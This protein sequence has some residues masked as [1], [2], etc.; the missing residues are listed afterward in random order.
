[1]KNRAELKKPYAEIDGEY[2][3]KDVW[4]NALLSVYGIDPERVE[5]IDG[6][7]YLIYKPTKELKDV[8]TV[9]SLGSATVKLAAYMQAYKSTLYFIKNYDK[10]KDVK[11]EKTDES[12]KAE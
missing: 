1:M 2:Y 8:I 11:N 9:F 6:T 10:F 3:V 5:Q 12:G 4:L 7:V